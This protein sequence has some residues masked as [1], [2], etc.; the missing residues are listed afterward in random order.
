MSVKDRLLKQA[1]SE[2]SGLNWNKSP[3]NT[4]LGID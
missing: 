4:G 3:Q 2:M 1:E